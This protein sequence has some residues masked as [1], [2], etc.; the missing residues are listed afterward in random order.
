MNTETDLGPAPEEAELIAYADGHLAVESPRGR[1]IAAWLEQHPGVRRRLQDYQRQDEDIRAHY[2]PLL[3]AAVPPHLQLDGIRQH[4]DR[5]RSRWLAVAATC[6]FVALA[7]SWSVHLNEAPSGLDSFARGVSLQMQA[8]IEQEL[9][10]APVVTAPEYDFIPPGFSLRGERRLVSET[11]PLT[12]YLYTAE[13]G[14]E[15][16]LFVGQRERHEPDMPKWLRDEDLSL[17]YWEQG[18]QL[19]ALSGN[20]SEPELESVALQGMLQQIPAEMRAV[21]ETLPRPD[22][23]EAQANLPSQVILPEGQSLQGDGR[24]AQIEPLPGTHQDEAERPTDIQPI[25]DPSV[26]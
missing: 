5:Y 11:T 15:L 16:R 23:E 3:A 12:E 9:Q 10:S 13:D 17:V 2:A 6:G 14:R 4:R 25:A 7:L 21:D 1:E 18:S 20:L 19:F 22:M 24:P 26:M 8:G